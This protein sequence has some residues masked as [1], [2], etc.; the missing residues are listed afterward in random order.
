[1]VLKVPQ[2]PLKISVKLQEP[3]GTENYAV[4]KMPIL[5][6]YK[7]YDYNFYNLCDKIIQIEKRL[8]VECKALSHR[9]TLR[10]PSWGVQL[11]SPCFL[12][13]PKDHSS[14]VTTTTPMAPSWA[15][16]LTIL[17]SNQVRT[18]ATASFLFA[19]RE[20][21]TIYNFLPIPKNKICIT[22]FLFLHY[23][24]IINKCISVASRRQQCV[25]RH[26]RGDRWLM[27]HFRTPDP[28]A[29]L[30]H[31]VRPGPQRPVLPASSSPYHTQR[32][33]E[34]RKWPRFRGQ[35]NCHAL[36]QIPGEMGPGT[37]R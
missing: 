37:P 30:R 28:Y 9:Y 29:T 18:G 35:V 11:P 23:F 33:T 20:I 3:G 4:W 16:A 21:Y 6:G 31:Q 19:T 32:L 36:S 10:I 14:K 12:L 15:L 1:M 13:S 7:P 2:S 8:G 27:N 17:P 24:L 26:L 22:F 34:G 25:H 5:K